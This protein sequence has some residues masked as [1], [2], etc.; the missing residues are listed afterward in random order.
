MIE[1]DEEGVG[2]GLESELDEIRLED[3]VREDDFEVEEIRE[4]VL[5]EDELREVML[6]TK[7]WQKQKHDR[8]EG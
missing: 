2:R 5:E 6:A 3:V 7:Y 4:L 1:E 8:R